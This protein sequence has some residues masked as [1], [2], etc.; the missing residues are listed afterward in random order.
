MQN[1][2]SKPALVWLSIKPKV[3]VTP[4]NRY[5]INKL[6]Y[7]KPLHIMAG[8]FSFI[9]YEIVSVYEIPL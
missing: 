2:K 8:V 5:T 9:V 4:G 7:Y 1:R 6:V 3:G